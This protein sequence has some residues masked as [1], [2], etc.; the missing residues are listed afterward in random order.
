[1]EE[2]LLFSRLLLLLL[3]SLQSGPTLRDPI[4]GSP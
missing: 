4:D 1:M 3:L 2:I